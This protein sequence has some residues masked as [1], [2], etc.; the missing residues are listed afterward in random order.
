[1]KPTPLPI[2]GDTIERPVMDMKVKPRTFPFERA[3]DLAAFANHL[4][5]TL[6]IGAHETDQ[7]LRAY[8]GMSDA[9]AGSVLDGYSKAVASRCHPR[10]A[11]D[12]EQ[13]EDPGDATKR[14]VAINV[15]PSLNLVGVAIHADKVNEGWGD[16]AYVFPVRSGT[17]A[18][19]LQ[20]EQLAMF[21][22]PQVRRIAVMLS[23]IPKGTRVQ[24]SRPV[25]TTALPGRGVHTYAAQLDAVLEQENVAAFTG[26]G[27]AHGRRPLSGRCCGA[28]DTADTSCGVSREGVQGRHADSCGASR[29]RLGPPPS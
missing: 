21:M 19:Y 27:P 20:P 6:L 29:V 23:K 11:V 17:D 2:V 3:R 1:M 14:V 5:G 15:Q 28:S 8:V 4:G 9:D 12:F 16:N 10:P 22:T 13:Y 18:T 26:E 7:Q 25:V 24:I